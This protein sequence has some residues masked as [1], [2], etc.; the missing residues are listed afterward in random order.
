MVTTDTE[1]ARE[2]KRTGEPET[3]ER[4]GPKNSR[5]MSE[6]VDLARP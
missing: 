5:A 1:T 2:K 4:T 3:E 6:P